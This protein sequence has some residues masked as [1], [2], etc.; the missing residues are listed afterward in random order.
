MTIDVKFFAS[1]REQIGRSEA[2]LDASEPLSVA[3]VWAQATD[4]A[5]L[6]ANVLMARNME[7]VD[8]GTPVHD[9]DE[10][11]FFPPVTGG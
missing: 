5:E 6:P 9:G 3:E 11:A 4:N 1:L 2:R 10:V 8:S 7:Y